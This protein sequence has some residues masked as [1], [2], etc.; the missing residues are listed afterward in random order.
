MANFNESMNK[1][2]LDHRESNSASFVSQW[3]RTTPDQVENMFGCQ[4]Y[5][6]IPKS[7]LELGLK[8]HLLVKDETE[9]ALT[10][11]PSEI[12]GI[13]QIS[14]GSDSIG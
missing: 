10:S 4:T 14:Q 1:I 9:P 13:G 12:V 7:F 8:M 6:V 11:F 5:F 2:I 3:I